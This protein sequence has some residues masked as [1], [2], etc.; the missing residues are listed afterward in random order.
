MPVLKTRNTKRK[1]KAPQKN[2]EGRKSSSS[3][4][5]LGKKVSAKKNSASFNAESN[6]PSKVGDLE[7]TKSFD[8]N[9]GVNEIAELMD[10]P[11]GH[12]ELFFLSLRDLAVDELRNCQKFVLPG[13]CTIK[14]T[15]TEAKSE[16]EG[17]NPFTKE[18]CTFKAVPA[19][20]KLKVSSVHCLTRAL[21]HD[22]IRLPEKYTPIKKSVLKKMAS[23]CSID[24]AMAQE[25]L[26]LVEV[27][28]HA[29]IYQCGAFAL[30]GF[31]KLV[32]KMSKPVPERE[33]LN[34]FTKKKCVFKGR[35]ALR[36]IFFE[37]D[38][39]IFQDL[40]KENKTTNSVEQGTGEGLNVDETLKGPG[41]A[42]SS[43]LII[44]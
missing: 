43:L 27:I 35:P 2:V 38:K 37:A 39:S 12:I 3:S 14:Y 30:P 13:F 32:M 21:N 22:L 25:F 29:E 19:G 9:A 16:R 40:L 4:K 8:E 24:E 42:S 15:K 5:G 26:D 44:D 20:Q 23:D 31:G 17:V 7:F 1:A 6:L 28:G 10:L 11:K 36:D 33:G 18:P 41:A 34:Q